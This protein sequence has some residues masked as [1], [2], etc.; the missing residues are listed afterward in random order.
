VS[1]SVNKELYPET[2]RHFSPSGEFIGHLNELQSLD[3]RIQIMKE[4]IDG[5]SF[6]D[7]NGDRIFLETSGDLSKT[8]IIYKGAF[9]RVMQIR[10]LQREEEKK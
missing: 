3:L 9:N 6:E 7:D 8:A 1:I 4:R 5:Y 10:R 2:A